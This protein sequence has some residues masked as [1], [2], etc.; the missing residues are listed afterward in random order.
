MNGRAFED[1]CWPRPKAHRTHVERPEDGSL[2]M[3]PI[4]YSLCHPEQLS[5]D[6]WRKKW[7]RHCINLHVRSFMEV[8]VFVWG[9]FVGVFLCYFLRAAASW[10]LLI[11]PSMPP[12][13]H[14]SVYIPW[15]SSRTPSRRSAMQ[16]TELLSTSYSQTL[17]CSRVKVT[18][19]PD[20]EPCMSALLR[21]DALSSHHSLT[22][23]THAYSGE[24]HPL[25]HLSV[26][27]RMFN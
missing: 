17:E 27:R 22:S 3:P 21:R 14:P 23:Y 5:V 24:G 13:L 10:E 9:M 19:R 11:H 2:L 7:W 15:Q 20:D 8:C 18:L 16:K 25:S 26:G 4:Q 12:S 1:N 6:W